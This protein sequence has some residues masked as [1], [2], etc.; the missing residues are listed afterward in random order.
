MA[1]GKLKSREDIVFG[2][3]MF[4]EALLRLFAGQKL[5]KLVLRI[6]EE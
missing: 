5:G 1:A 2:F 4:P 3:D 6:T